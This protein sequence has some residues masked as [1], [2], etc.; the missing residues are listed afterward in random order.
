MASNSAKKRKVDAENR[1]FNEEWTDKY[2]FILPQSS[3][4]P[5]CL[6]CSE[7]VSV[8]KNA[9][10]KRHY[11]SK[12][13][14]FEQQ[15]P[16][17]TEI[18]DTKINQLKSSYESSSRQFVRCVT[19]Q[20][21]ATEAS[22][23]VAWVLGKNKKPFSDS[24]LVKECL[25]E[26]VDSMFTGKERQDLSDKFKQIPLSNS[27]S[28]RRTELLADDVL[29]QLTGDLKNAEYI[30][31]A[32]DESTDNTDKA[33]LCAFVRYFSKAKAEICED[34]LGLIPL[35]GRTRGE[36]IYEAIMEMLRDRGIDI[37]KVVSVAT[38]GAPAMIG[39][40]KGVVSR[41]KEHQP[42]ML[43]YH[44][45]IHQS[46]LC[47]S[48]GNEYADVMETIM[49]LVNYLRASSALQHRLLRSFLNEVNASYDDLLLHNNVRWLSKGQVLG[50]FWA[51]KK[52]LEMFLSQQTTAKARQFLDYLRDDNK[53]ELVAFLVDITS[54]L[55]EFNLK[56]QGQGS[57]VCD[58]MTAVRSFERR[59]ELFKNDITEAHL[60][61]P[62][63]LGHTNGNH[64]HDHVSFLEKLAD[65][66]KSRFSD[67]CVGKQVLLCIGSPFLVKDLVELSRETTSIFPWANAGK[68]Q[69]EMI[70]LQENLALKE[71]LLGVSSGPSKKKFENP[72]YI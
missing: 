18:R 48:L 49:K 70:D 8:S 66:F 1:V 68:L 67:F 58:L 64:H 17:N 12:H 43:S 24:E 16:Q 21:K 57:T 15:Y 56:L 7:T 13:N 11:D 69:T 51:I 5:M 10:L 44:C 63:L 28:T 65:N 59:L 61:F 52:D 23:R 46:V 20:Q 71:S 42:Y 19:Q 3:T 34:I 29:Q 9:N 41:L 30:A 40:Q 36:D 33:Q 2:A 14:R 27:T 38:D 35:L 32:L 39:R 55:N 4:R 47:A 6:I 50:R 22:L 62:T 45:I 31:L 25:N 60:H 37:K 54:H 72:C 26:V 53:M